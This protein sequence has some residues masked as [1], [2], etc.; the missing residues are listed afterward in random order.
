[1][2][3]KIINILFSGTCIE[4][5]LNW[6]LTIVLLPFVSIQSRL[7][8]TVDAGMLVGGVDTVNE[9]GKK[10]DKILFS[11][12]YIRYVSVLLNGWKRELRVSSSHVYQ[13]LFGFA[14][15]E[16][17]SKKCETEEEI[18]AVN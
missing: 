18:N 13:E 4:L 3:K 11:I 2:E 9:N 17:V 7:L 12:P 8:S 16:D 14:N 15:P 10:G 6:P 1:M 5:I